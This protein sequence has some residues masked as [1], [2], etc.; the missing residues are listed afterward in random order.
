MTT[1]IKHEQG[2]RVARK[3]HRGREELADRRQ[4]EREA[5]ASDDA[6]SPW[7]AIRRNNKR[8]R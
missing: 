2:A 3:L 4:A 5:R 7:R 8:V 6:P 1:N